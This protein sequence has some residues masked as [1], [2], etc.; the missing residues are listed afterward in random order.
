MKAPTWQEYMRPAL[1][2]LSDGVTR[3]AREVVREAADLMQVSDDHRQIMIASGQEQWMNRGNW[4]LSYLTRAEA[5]ERPS[6]GH[7]VVTDV[8]RKL[9]VDFPDGITERDLRSLPHYE[10]P[11][12][13]RRNSSTPMASQEVVEEA[14][15]TVLD[16]EEQISAGIARINADVADQLLKRVLG[17]E[18]VFFEQAVLDLL[19]AMGYGGAEGTATRT[20][21][22]RDGGIDGIIDQDALGLSR[23]YVQAKRYSDHNVIGRPDIQAFV[24]ALA[25]N[26]AHQGVF[27]TTSRF[28]SDA[29]TYIDQ[30]PSRV[31][32]IDGERL[33]RLM[34]RYGVGIQIKHTVHIV[35]VDEDFFE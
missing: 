21:L 27:I 20:Q 24:G 9:L 4:A 15:D 17:Q 3:R 19:M 8:G 11:R 28:S 14:V 25:G 32:L 30:I 12:R 18:P 22:A 34:I 2:I 26:Q 31:V 33:V 13:S 7:Y 35:E 6:R 5:V 10:S 1:Q 23:I 29:R 16:P